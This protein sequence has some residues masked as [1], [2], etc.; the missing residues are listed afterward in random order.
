M[1]ELL[2][3]LILHYSNTLIGVG[4]GILISLLL[5][6][7]VFFISQGRKPSLLTYAICL[8][9]I[10]FTSFR[11]ARIY[12]AYELS[13]TF[14]AI[15]TSANFVTDT[16]GDAIQES[17]IMDNEI[18]AAAASF[19]PGVSELQETIENIM[20]LGEETAQQV[21]GYITNFVIRRVLWSCLFIVIAAVGMFFTMTTDSMATS[22]YTRSRSRS[23]SIS[24]QRRERHTSRSSRTHRY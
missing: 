6:A 4:I 10:P 15:A 19:I 20:S 24:S 14:E 16:V 17:G 23:S 22:D 18:V 21:R 7:V 12:G 13:N 8:L 11:C 3:N 2:Y 1:E 9:L 5:L